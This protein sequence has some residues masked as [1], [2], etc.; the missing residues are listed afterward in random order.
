[1]VVARVVSSDEI[2]IRGIVTPLFFD[3]KRKVLKHPAFLPPPNRNRCDVSLLRLRYTTDTFCKK[4]SKTL[5][6]GNSIYW[7][8]ARFKPE[9]IDEINQA[10]N[11]S[12]SVS[13]LA[14]PLDENFVLVPENTVVTVNDPGLPMH[15]DM[16]YST[17]MEGEVQSEMRK[18]AEELIR[19]AAFYQDTNPESDEWTGPNLSDG[20]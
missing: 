2:L 13:I 10:N 3:K 1:M 15:A 11:F 9:D 8:L 16:I 17:A 7:G 6:I 18:F 20:S 4:H 19:L 5:T 12:Y 14:T